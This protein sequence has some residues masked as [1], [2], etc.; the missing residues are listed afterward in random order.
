MQTI[1]PPSLTLDEIIERARSEGRSTL[2][3]TE[4]RTLLELL[5]VGVPRQIDIPVDADIAAVANDACRRLTGS[6]LVVKIVAANILHKTELGGVR[7]VERRPE[8]LVAAMAAMRESL[9]EYD[10]RGF[11]ISEFVEYDHAPGS[12]LLLGMRWTRDFGPIVSFGPGGV[13]AEFLAKNLR[14]GREVTILSPKLAQG[15]SFKSILARNAITPLV[16]G[17]RGQRGRMSSDELMSILSRFID[18]AST[19]IPS[20]I[21]EM[22]IN[23]L[24]PTSYLPVALDVLVRLSDDA[25]F[26]AQPPRPIE[27]IGRLLAPASA[28]VMGVSRAMNPGHIIVN[29]LLREGFDREKIYVIKPG[30]DEIEGCRCVP[31]LASLPHPVDVLVL[32]IAADQ[33]PAVVDQVIATRKAESVIVIPGGLGE[34]E[35]SEN[36]EQR[37]R[38]SVAASRSTDWRGPVINGPNCLGVSSVPGKVNTI[39]LPEVKLRTGAPA[40]HEVP[41]AIVSQSGAFCVAKATKLTGLRPRYLVSIGNQIDLTVGDYLN[42]L[43]QDEN[44][45]VYAFYVEGF[46]P[47]DGLRWMEAAARITARGRPVIL[48]SAGKTAEGA[49]ATASHTAAIAGDAVVT[50]E[51]AASAGV[52]YADTLDEFEDLMR[53]F[54][55]LSQKDPAGLRLGA[56]SNAGFESVAFADT[57][58]PFHMAKLGSATEGRIAAVIRE[59]RLDKIVTLR[60]PLDVNPLMNDRSFSDVF[61]AL[62]ADPEVDVAILGCVPLTGS[63]QTLTKSAEH[64]EDVAADEAVVAHLARIWRESAKPWVCVIDGGSI[65]D[66]MARQLEL[67]G[68]PTFR[69]AD[70]A[71]R[72]FARWCAWKMR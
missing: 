15:R 18:F 66:A 8:E 20:P 1:A 63:L 51:L 2:L 39:F 27:K 3:E 5:G 38:Q 25:T 57:L 64:R 28:A 40:D 6:R 44:I 68:I 11:L 30:E 43:E 23:P 9:G 17:I 55:M 54:T 62:L 71:M 67:A 41:L 7:I 19:H 53:L 72:L 58:G 16:T 69:T 10:L 56:M 46:Q 22:E 12:E 65:Y 21:A 14:P 36:L 37:I 61:G 29:N 13:S 47:L 31:D 70:R 50:R 45:R 33:V 48:Y 35:G 34:H 4:A 59:N 60:N 42:Y 26:T 32:S 24:V 52:I 49:R